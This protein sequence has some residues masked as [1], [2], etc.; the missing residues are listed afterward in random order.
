MFRPARVGG[1]GGK[2]KKC[3]DEREESFLRIPQFLIQNKENS[4]HI[5]EPVQSTE[6]ERKRG[7]KEHT[8]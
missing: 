2:Q 5:Q 6:K 3:L 8:K 7:E 1:G 4:L